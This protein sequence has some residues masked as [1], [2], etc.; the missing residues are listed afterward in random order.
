MSLTRY[1]GQGLEICDDREKVAFL[2]KKSKQ[3]EM[4]LND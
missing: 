2:N 4:L 3:L 1:I